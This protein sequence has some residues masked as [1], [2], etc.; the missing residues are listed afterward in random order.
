MTDQKSP[1]K[2]GT[3]RSTLY[4]T[5]QVSTQNT[6]TKGASHSVNPLSNLVPYAD[7]PTESAYSQD[8]PLAISV[9]FLVKR[10][11]LVNSI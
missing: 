8:W 1:Q 6:V 4:V 10:P 2:P 11:T 5:A 3:S 7:L 9:E